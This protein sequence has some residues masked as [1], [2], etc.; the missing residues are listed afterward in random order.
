MIIQQFDPKCQENLY[1][2]IFTLS[3]RGAGFRIKS[4]KQQF[5]KCLQLLAELPL[6][7]GIN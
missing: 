2:H 7:F 5:S 4:K 3:V 1:N 6:V